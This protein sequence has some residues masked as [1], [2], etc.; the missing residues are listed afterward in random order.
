MK[1]RGKFISLF[2]ILV[3]SISLPFAISFT[4][5]I[6]SL[7]QN[8]ILV[9]IFIIGALAFILISRRITYS[10]SQLLDGMDVFLR[11]D[12]TQR[13]K[14]RSKD[15]IGE[16]TDAFNQ[17]A[18]MLNNNKKELE[19]IKGKLR[20]STKELKNRIS[21][22]S[23]LNRAT[24]ILNSTLD[25]KKKYKLIVDTAI[26]VMGAKKGLLIFADQEGDKL[27]VKCM[28]GEDVRLEL[29][30]ELARWVIRNNEPFLLDG[31]A[32]D[33]QFKGLV[34]EKDTGAIMCVP[35]ETKDGLTGVISVEHPIFKEE[36][37]QNDLELFSTFVNEVA[38]V[39]ENAFLTD[40]LI[41][42]RELDSFNRI[43]SVIIHD[44]KG[45]I[46]GLSLLLANTE[47]NYDDPEFRADLVTTIADTV[48]KIEDLVARLNSN[49]HLL[50]LKSESINRIIQNIIDRLDLRKA[51][52]IE[53]IEEY[54]ELPNLMIDEKNME[55]VFKNLILNALEAM[56]NGGK[57]RITS[58]KEENPLTAVV[59]I[60]DT[61]YGMTEEFINNG[62]FKP[63][64]TTKRKGLGLGLFSC[65]EIISLHGGKI[66]VK[67]KPGKGTTF[68]VRLPILAIDGRLKAIRKLLGEYLL[69]EGTISEVQLEKALK[70]QSSD[71]R[72]I[73]RILIDL[74]Y[75]EEQEIVSVLERQKEAE[76]YLC[77]ILSRR[78]LSNEIGISC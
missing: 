23:A 56:P 30:R 32:K 29:H 36:F 16:L 37:T 61:G 67:S 22:L 35:L 10:I 19:K 21:E 57:L 11:G 63:F 44:L 25:L 33:L 6:P 74:G 64:R 9:V 47:Q 68:A 26:S 65:R 40:T 38:L 62:L 13:I 51:E 77:D 50:E 60:T 43:T 70:I 76:K 66:E 1:L 41:E 20:S 8:V 3:F 17:L 78:R 73:G 53:L 34:E 45:S 75:V 48:K 69:E 42:S 14:L 12:F 52:D 5:R 58:Q 59:E 7:E 18:E 39:L 24:K 72:R 27:D 54:E 55:R 49:P 15:E 71:K 2:I 4:M 28:Q 46:S 31:K